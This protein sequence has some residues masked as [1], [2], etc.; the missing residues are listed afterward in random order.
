MEKRSRLSTADAELAL[1][2][3]R[4]L[5]APRIELPER[6]AFL[7]RTLSLGGL[8]LLTGCEVTSQSGVEQALSAVSR[9][10][11]RVQGWLFDPNALAPTYPAS[12]ITRPFPFNAYYGVDEAPTVDEADYRLEIAGRVADRRPWRLADLRALPQAE[13]ITRHICVEGW[14]AIGRWGGV[15][16]PDFLARIG[17]DTSARYVGFK[18]ADDYYTSI[19]MATALHPQTLLT[20]SYDG[21]TLPR[22]YGFPMKLRMPTKL[23]YKNPKH[24]RAIFVTNAYPG[25]YWEDQG[26]NWFGGS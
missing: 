12:M 21:R 3:A 7:T 10:N 15:R 14:S 13:Q 6:R 19:D 16:F 11:D 9:F 2:E 24:V 1:R 8:A 23:G 4:Q 17:A 25:G 22:E 5:L 18:C 26:Y 20:L